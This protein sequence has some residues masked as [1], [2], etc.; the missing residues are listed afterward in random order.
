MEH[1]AQL[2]ARGSLRIRDVAARVGYRQPSQFA[3]A[4]RRHH[5]TAPAVFREQVAPAWVVARRTLAGDP[6][7]LAGLRA[8]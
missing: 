6:G 4:F 7:P 1:A 8:A 3:K 5:G 2:L